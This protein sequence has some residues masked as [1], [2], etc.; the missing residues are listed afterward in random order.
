MNKTVLVTGSSR[1]LGAAIVRTLSQQGYNVIINYFQ[2]KVLA[3]QLVSEL[4][5]HQAIAIQA[6]VTNRNDV[7]KLIIQATE[8]FGHIDAVV[9]NALVGFKFDPTQQKPF[10]DLSWDD[11][12]QQLD[13]TLKSAFN[14]IQSV[15]PQFLERQSGSI[16]SIG[17]NLYQNPVVPYHE[18][19]TAKAGLIGL[20]R[21]IA[22]ELGQFGITA[23]V[24]SGGLL[25]TT[26]ASAAT[27]AEVFDLIAQTTP[28]KKVTAPQD[29][30]N[31]VAYLVSDQAKGITGQNF[32]IDGGLTMN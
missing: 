21:N 11:Y 14:V 3:E 10:K 16:I 1:G 29:V 15:L 4:G 12:Q 31:M 23:N 18:Y 22:A 27:T 28:L 6:D 19:T 8:Y 5:E 2:N 26:D 30:A 7:E 25:K 20:T 32:T 17:T 24:V 13:G 9:N